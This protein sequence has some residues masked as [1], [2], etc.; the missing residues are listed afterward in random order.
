MSGATETSEVVGLSSF[1]P[2][3]EYEGS[4]VDWL[5][6]LPAG[7]KT[8]RLKH[9]VRVQGGGTPSKE[10]PDYWL[11]DIPWVSPKDMKGQVVSDTIDHITPEA[12]AQS[13]TRLVENGSVLVVVRSGILNHSIPVAVSAREVALNQ[14][15]K[16]LI[17]RGELLPPYLAYFIIGMQSPLLAEWRK[18]GATV[19]S[20]QLDLI[21]DTRVPVPL[22]EEQ[23]AIADFLDRET[24]KIDALVEKKERL[25]E[26]LKEKRAALITRAV[27]KGLEPD[28][29]MKDSGVEWL[30]EIPRHW[31]VKRIKHLLHQIVDTEH[32]TAPFHPDGEF[33]VA[34]TS[35]VKNGRLDMTDARFTGRA[36][37]EE[38]T[39]REIPLPGDIL[40]TREAPAGEACL[41]PETPVLCL[42]QRMVLFKVNR[43][44]LD[45]RFA[46]YALYGGL[47]DEFVQLL[48]QGSTVAH[49]NMADIGNIP[50]VAPPL[51]EQIAISDYID[52]AARQ[53]DL[54]LAGVGEGIDRLKEFRT[55]LISAAV[56]GRIDVRETPA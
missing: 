2:Y 56:T 49:F 8:R 4:G 51:L 37:Y 1:R 46:V 33:L 35:N 10:N 39:R 28:T 17:S 40:F 31:E 32:K 41:V 34:R 38:W 21:A 47:A 14:D 26:L 9:L 18:E 24:G 7:W 53:L 3:S 5:G 30:G 20:L 15:L 55:A 12:V 25:V 42:G 13:A 16:A 54:L 50:L 19:E 11:G 36:S 52:T 27:T 45:G 22:L 43:T 48:S 23:R 44:V 29:P 6:E